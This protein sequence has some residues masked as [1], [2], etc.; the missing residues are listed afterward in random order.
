MSNYDDA[1]LCLLKLLVNTRKSP[2]PQ[3]HLAWNATDAASPNTLG[4][5][6]AVEL[7]MRVAADAAAASRSA[8]EGGGAQGKID[9]V[10]MYSCCCCDCTVAAGDSDISCHGNLALGLRLATDLGL[11]L[12]LGLHTDL[13]LG[14]PLTLGLRCRQGR[15]RCGPPSTST[16]P[17]RAAAHNK[18]SLAAAEAASVTICAVTGESV[19]LSRRG[20]GAAAAAATMATEPRGR[21]FGIAATSS[22]AG[23]RRAVGGAA[24]FGAAATCTLCGGGGR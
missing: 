6:V 19:P 21:A 9:P 18:A 11:A 2:A 20:G 10:H 5:T 4:T 15:R 12:G 14:L 23:G 16:R 8:A 13:G 24:G 17:Q 7:H 3:I 22:A 1:I